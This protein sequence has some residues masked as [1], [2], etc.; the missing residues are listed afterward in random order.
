MSIKKLEHFNDHRAN[1]FFDLYEDMD[2]NGQVTASLILPN[3]FSGWHMHY[4]QFDQFTVVKGCIKV[5]TI[6]PEGDIIEHF[7][8][9][10]NPET[11]RIEPGYIHCY[12]SSDEEALLIYYLSQKHN[13]DDEYRFSEEEILEKFNYKV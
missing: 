13:E 3:Q 11:L 4:L 2:G 9:A 5:V 10:D 8:R 12:K 6:S 1:R 7:L